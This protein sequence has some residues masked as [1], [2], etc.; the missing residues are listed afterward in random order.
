MDDNDATALFE[1]LELSP[2]P[3]EELSNLIQGIIPPPSLFEH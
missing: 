1:K 2:A 3:D